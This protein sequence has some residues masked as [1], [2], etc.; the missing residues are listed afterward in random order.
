MRIRFAPFYVIAAIV[1]HNNAIIVIPISSV[2]RRNRHLIQGT[3][4]TAA[5]KS[6]KSQ[7]AAPLAGVRLCHKSHT[8]Y[9]TC[10]K[11]PL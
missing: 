4:A 9:R 7:C 8:F 11:R 5:V 1:P 10:I 3:V 2:R 6:N